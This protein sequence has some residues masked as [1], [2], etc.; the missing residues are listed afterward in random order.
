MFNIHNGNEV[1]LTFIFNNLSDIAMYIPHKYSALQN[2]VGND[3]FN[4]SHV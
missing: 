4:N 1:Y 3:I 2:K